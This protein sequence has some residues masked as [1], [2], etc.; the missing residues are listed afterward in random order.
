MI[1]MEMQ[2]KASNPNWKSKFR[3]L[4]KKQLKIRTFSIFLSHTKTYHCSSIRRCTM[5]SQEN[6]KTV[7]WISMWW[8]MVSVFRKR[9]SLS[10]SNLITR[11][12]AQIVNMEGRVLVCGFQNRWLNLCK[13]T[14]VFTLLD[15]AQVQPLRF[16]RQWR[17]KYRPRAWVKSA[18][19][20]TSLNRNILLIDYTEPTVLIPM[21][22]NA[23]RFMSYQILWLWKQSIVS[24][25]GSN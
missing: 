13:V 16:K 9:S 7:F 1:P 25:S 2:K 8:T 3:I 10:S 21:F 14:L 4:R 5:W 23:K 19:P 24:Y 11:L 20:A 12:M 22:N 15:T 18:S 6:G 17:L